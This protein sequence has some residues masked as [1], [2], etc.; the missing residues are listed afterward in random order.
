MSERVPKNGCPKKACRKGLPTQIRKR[1][2]KHV[3]HKGLPTMLGKKACQ[4]CLLKRPTNKCFPKRLAKEGLSKRLVK[5]D[6][7]KGLLKRIAK[8][9]MQSRSNNSQDFVIS[10]CV[11]ML[12]WSSCTVESRVFEDLFS[13]AVSNPVFFSSCHAEGRIPERFYL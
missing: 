5:Q 9:L 11:E 4:T 1:I 7:Q 13:H 2:V 6:C 10:C 8:Q 12:F 3:C